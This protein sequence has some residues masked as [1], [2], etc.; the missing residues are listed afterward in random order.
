M[1]AAFGSA[2]SVSG[3][4]TQGTIDANWSGS[5]AEFAL[6]KLEG[7]VALQIGKGRLL[8][9]EAGAG[10][11]FGLL[12]ITG[13][14][15]RLTLDF[16][17]V[18]AKG[19]AFDSIDGKL[20]LQD[21]DAYT[22]DLVID[23]PAARIE[24][25]GRTGLAKR[26]Y[27][28]LVTVIPHAQSTLPLAGAIAGGPA[29]GAALLL[30]DKLLGR[31]ME[32]LTSFTRYQYTVTGGWDE[33]TFTPVPSGAARGLQDKPLDEPMPAPVSPAVPE[34]APEATPVPADKPTQD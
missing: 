28:Q 31:Q 25:S 1:L 10:R 20:K 11:L 14:R 15:R 5:P 33:P 6:A 18:F 3:G 30:A 2:G 16:S 24:V 34:V 17:D 12:N 4:E 22:D 9:V 7:N 26:D 21:G 13:L 32:G 8:N 19:F 29:V 23:G 27:D